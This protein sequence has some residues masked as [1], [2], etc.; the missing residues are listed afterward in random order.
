[1]AGIIRPTRHASPEAVRLA[2]TPESWH[3]MLG[4]DASL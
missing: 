4:D 1:V 2:S 3:V